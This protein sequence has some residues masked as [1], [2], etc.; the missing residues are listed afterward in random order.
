[1]SLIR[2]STIFRLS[3]F[4]N[5]PSLGI[6]KAQSEI[7]MNHHTIVAHTA[8]AAV[9]VSLA[10]LVL[11]P[12]QYGTVTPFYG[13]I[14]APFLFLG[15]LAGAV[16]VDAW[17]MSKA[18]RQNEVTTENIRRQQR[19]ARRSHGWTFRWPRNAGQPDV[20]DRQSSGR[21]TTITRRRFPYRALE[22][23]RSTKPIR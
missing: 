21:L 19:S 4:P 13:F 10:G 9:F 16:C 6:R 14:A 22:A 17:L 12:Y 20:R 18:S 7:T 3:R 15:A 1:M 11:A 8:A 2:G 23:G 5:R